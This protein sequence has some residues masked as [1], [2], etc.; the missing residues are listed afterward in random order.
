ME[1]DFPL[2]P[3]PR[4]HAETHTL[5]SLP[6]NGPSFKHAIKQFLRVFE[7][8]EGLLLLYFV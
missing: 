7:D 1:A 4:P 3:F 2:L 8:E 5:G 6:K